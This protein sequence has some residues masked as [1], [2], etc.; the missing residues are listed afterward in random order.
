LTSTVSGS[1]P[2]AAPSANVPRSVL[3]LVAAL[4]GFA[5]TTALAAD[6]LAPDVAPPSALAV[7]G[8]LLALTVA[9]TL[10]LEY[11]Y[12]GQTDA[13]DHFEVALIPTLYYLPPAHVVVLAIIAKVL[14][15]TYRRVQPVRAAF[16]VAQWAAAAGAGALAFAWLQ[17]VLPA[18]QEM[19]PLGLATL[20]VVIVNKAAIG[21]VLTAVQHG[22]AGPRLP[23]GATALLRTTAVGGLVNISFGMLFVAT[24]ESARVATPLLVVLLGLLHWASRGYTVGRLEQMRLRMMRLATYALGAATDSNAAMADFLAAVGAGL[25]REVVELVITVPGGLEVH[26]WHHDTEAAPVTVVRLDEVGPLTRALLA[27]DRPIRADATRGDGSLRQLMRAEGQRDF[28]AAPLP[29][30]SSGRGVLALYG[31][32]AAVALPDIELAIIAELAREV[33]LARER[34]GLAREVLAERAKMTQIVTQTGD[35]IV[36]IG[37]DGTVHTWNPALERITGFTAA[38]VLSS[39]RLDLLHPVDA[40]GRPVSLEA[41]TAGPDDAPRDVLVRTRGGERRWLSC[42]YARGSSETGAPDRLIIMA[43]DVT[44]LKN[45]EARLAGQTAVLEHIASG[46]SIGV[47]LQVLADDLARSDDDV[48][49]AVLLTSGIDPLRLDAVALSGTTATVLADLDALRV[50]PLAGWPGRAVHRR[51]AIFI[52][53]VET[54]GDSPAVLLGARTHRIRSCSA[55]PIRASDGDRIIGVL[56]LFGRRP[57]PHADARDRELLERAAHLAAVAVARSEFEAQLEHQATHDALTGLPNRSVLIERCE[58]ALAT[59][60]DAAAAVMLFLDVDRFKLVNDSMGHDAGDQLLIEIAE[61]LRGV[62]RPQDTVARFG[63]DEFT[64][65]CEEVPDDTFV[66]DLAD[67]VQAIFAQPFALRGNDVTVTASVG[68]AVGLPG[69]DADDLVANADA[70][71]YRAKERGGNRYELYDASMRGPALLHL[72]THNAL[73]RALDKGE[74]VVFYQPIA[75]LLSGDV[76][77][78]EAP[79]RWQHPDRGL[80]EPSSFLALAENTGLIVPIG[81]HVVSV[82]CN[83]AKRW[84]TA[85]PYGT[86]LRMNINLS[87]RELGQAELPRTVAAALDRSGADPATICFEITE[88]ALL[89]DVNAT[90]VTLRQLKE[91]GVE[92]AIDDFGTGYSALTHLRRFPVDGL[93]VDR[94]FVSGLDDPDDRAIVTAV[95]GLAQSL[96]LSTTAEG[97]ETAGQLATLKSLGCEAAQGFYLAPPKPPEDL[98]AMWSPAVRAG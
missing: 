91:L 73:H 71:M 44:E 50:A 80:L 20:A 94:S 17:D 96:Q 52:D 62:V 77:G 3:V 1:D 45:A 32:R 67:R 70:A 46:E 34:A 11:H 85:G 93:K 61:R 23:G 48:A 38:E 83:Q 84:K 51:R 87:A 76:V 24:A 89:Y 2:D 9:G 22:A 5:A 72:V 65:M 56:A 18:E 33:G 40:A 82:A 26:R 97:V 90:A 63:G 21:L 60:R 27:L 88:S 54:H 92:L 78:V 36:T 98:V 19:L 81:A 66:V 28:A 41:W 12:R 47:S 69:S 68:V 59:H 64:V 30:S 37:P 58:H 74:L 95:I 8:V 42:S 86:P 57:R 75:S 29:I 15:Q 6:R 43:R 7:V 53:D 31:A 35:G 14:C 79:L 10:N 25:D 13:V 49:C 16:N 4:T 39:A 55:V